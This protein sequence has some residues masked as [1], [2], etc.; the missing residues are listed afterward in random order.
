MTTTSAAVEKVVRLE[1]GRVLATLIRLAGDFQ[2]AED[3]LQDALTRALERW[4]VD[5]V[6]DNPAAW[7]ITTARRKSIDRLRRDA[8]AADKRAAI[9]AAALLERE[10]NRIAEE[11]Q[12]VV[13][14]DQLRLI[15]T[16]C[17]PALSREAQV[18]LTLRTLCGLTTSEIARAF[19]I[20]ETTMA[21]RLVRAKKKIRA[22][23]IP[24]VIPS[25]D[26]I[27]ER[28]STVLAVVYLIFNEGYSATS[29]NDVVR[30]DLCSDA[31]RLSRLVCRL[32][33]SRPE[34]VGLLALCLLHDSRRDARADA[35][36]DF[37][38]LEDQDRS[39]W[40][41][42][43]IAEGLHLV[44]AALT[45]G[46]VGPY[47]IQAAI[48]AVHANARTAAETDWK[49]IVALYDALTAFAPTAVI[50]L[51]RA[52]AVAMAFGY[53]RGLELLDA[54]ELA[55]S[56]RDYGLYHSARADLL[57]RLERYHDAAIAYRR[58]LAL[59]ENVASRRYLEGRLQVIEK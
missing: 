2:L 32:L 4:P 57:R 50:A 21:Q 13:P 43:K 31:V 40:D 36:G 34:A 22:A 20:P 6:P 14:D 12:Q 26:A 9:A 19:L 58:A 42:E 5:G 37:V 54:P 17:H 59:V 15:F 55:E 1:S 33:P 16:C 52:V 11:G 46:Q 53:E 41:S 38:L 25:R 30:G 35:N 27:P 7:L 49:Q 18:A 48:A 23:K 44:E 29:G 28:L 45:V 8:T 56:L 3:A 24:Y 51:N 47:Q 39:L 10:D